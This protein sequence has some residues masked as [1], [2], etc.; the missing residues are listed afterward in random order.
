MVMGIVAVPAMAESDVVMNIDKVLWVGQ[1]YNYVYV[2]GLPDDAEI[3]SVKS[4]EPGVLKV[5][6]EAGDTGFEVKPLKAGKTTLK[7]TYRLNGKKTTIKQAVRVKKYPNAIASLTVNG[8]SVSFKKN[9]F[10]Y[11][12]SKFTK[13]AVTIKV[14]AAKGWKVKGMYTD[15][16]YIGYSKIKNGKTFKLHKKGRGDAWIDL[17]NSKNQVFTYW[18]EINRV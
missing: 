16:E 15:L 4:T 7:Y 5:R 8:K 13:R 6:Y 9:K 2:D 1:G 14:K 12:V 11:I 18:I 10:R 17:V 3:V